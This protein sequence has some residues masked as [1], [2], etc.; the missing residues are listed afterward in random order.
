MR[1]LDSNA[2]DLVEK[3]FA[4]LNVFGLILGGTDFEASTIRQMAGTVLIRKR[5]S[6]FEVDIN[7]I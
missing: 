2:H 7:E 6:T 3:G 1:D 4:S 5:G